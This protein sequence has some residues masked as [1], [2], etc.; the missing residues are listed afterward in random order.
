ML[1]QIVNPFRTITYSFKDQF[2][3]AY[4]GL[5]GAIC[6]ALVFTLPDT[7]NRKSLFV[8]A[9]IAIIIFTVFIQVRSRRHV[10]R[11][12]GARRRS[13]VTLVLLSSGH[14]HP[15]H[16]RVHE[17]QE[18]QQGPQHH[19]CGG[20]HQGEPRPLALPTSLAPWVPHGVCAS[21]QVMEHVVSGIEDLCG[22]WSHYYWKDK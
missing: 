9:S 1:T 21:L 16:H 14:Q 13:L 12:G 8:T 5:R 18:D 15:S 3:L 19:Q 10:S 7:I 20:P 22:Q 6:F 17:H 11:V 2:S 4:G